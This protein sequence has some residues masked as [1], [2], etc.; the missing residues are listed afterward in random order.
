MRLKS[1]IQN[2]QYGSLTQGYLELIESCLVVTVLKREI[3]PKWIVQ[4]SSDVDKDAYQAT[5]GILCFSEK[6]GRLSLMLAV[7]RR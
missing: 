3:L 6:A 7:A 5:I 1:R 2:F 4:Q